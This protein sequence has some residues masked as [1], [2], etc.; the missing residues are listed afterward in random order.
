MVFNKTEKKKKTGNKGNSF[1]TV[2][3]NSPPVLMK[4]SL[5]IFTP[6][7]VPSGTTYP[8]FEVALAFL[9][10]QGL[11]SI[12]IAWFWTFRKGRTEYWGL[13]TF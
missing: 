2:Y 11:V 1:T 12:S 4:L 13:S 10:P 7:V 6:T 3:Y 8:V 9:F 5:G